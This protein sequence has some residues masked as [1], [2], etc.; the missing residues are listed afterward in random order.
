MEK[1]RMTVTAVGDFA[2]S[3]EITKCKPEVD[4]IWE[5]LRQSDLT[6]A[7]LEI[8]LTKAVAHADKAATIKADPSIA[9][10]FPESGIDVVTIANNHAL[11]YGAE[12]L[13]ETINVMKE[14]H[15]PTVGGGINLEE[16]ASPV[17]IEKEGV[18]FA[19]FGFASTLP[20]GYAAGPDRPGTA[21]IRAHS[22]FFLDNMTLDEQP[23]ISPWVETRVNEQD[24]AYACSRVAEAKKQ[25]DIVIVNIHW[26]IPHGWCAAFQGPLADYQTPLA[27]GLI[28][29][30]AD[31]ILGGHP[32]VVHPVERYKE[33]LVAYNLGNFLFHAFGEGEVLDTPVAYPPYQFES[34]MR[35][36]ALEAVILELVVED[37]KLA[38]ARFL[39][40]QLNNQGDP[41][42]MDETAAVTVL[43]RLNQLSKPFNVKVEIEAG[44]GQLKL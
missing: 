13:L 23:G 7:N 24:L 10:S 22:S 18:R 25:A 26:G 44:V 28:D 8:P 2:P 15:I 16:A 3:R 21:P 33:G 31:V 38:E 43:E 20:T 6:I 19:V 36:I 14:I 17:F 29:A 1:K 42:F 39:P 4:K 32:H 30:G 11:D 40:I 41:V 9:V 35:G 34:V 27:H 37:K 12:G 5:Y